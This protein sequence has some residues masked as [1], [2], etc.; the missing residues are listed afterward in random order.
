M[1]RKVYVIGP[2]TGYA[3]PIYNKELV[4][5]IEDAD[6]VLLTGGSD[7][8]PSTHGKP[9]EPESL[10]SRVPERLCPL[11]FRDNCHLP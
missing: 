10:Q 2:F 5:N 8:D 1:K 6:I 4:D 7:V 11:P 9:A 3:R